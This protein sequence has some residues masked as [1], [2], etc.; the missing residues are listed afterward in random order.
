VPVS[1]IDALKLPAVRLIKACVCVRVCRA[2]GS[3]RAQVDV[4]GMELEVLR[5]AAATI[6]AYA[7]VLYVENN[8]DPKSPAVV[9][10]LAAMDY[11]CYW[12]MA[13]CYAPDNNYYG[14][15][16][17][18][19]ISPVSVNMLCVSRAHPWNLDGFN[20]VEVPVDPANDADWLLRH[21]FFD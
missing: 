14:S 7:P 5:G 10:L 13:P 15:T 11:V 21:K 17:R 4:E 20:E 6:A 12:H 3:E 18:E 8:R 1:T 16:H 9:R 19:R 2:R